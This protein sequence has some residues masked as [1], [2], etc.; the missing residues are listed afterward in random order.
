MVDEKDRSDQEMILF[1][2]DIARSLEK[3]HTD[4]GNKLREC[5]DRFSELA[6][7]AATRR[8]WCNGQE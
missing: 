7:K 5:A 4:F 3:G 2:H 8:H 6:N 1:M